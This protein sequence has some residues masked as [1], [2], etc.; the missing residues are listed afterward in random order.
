MN[1]STKD[2]VSAIL[3]TDCNTIDQVKIDEACYRRME[4][5][6]KYYDSEGDKAKRLLRIAAELIDLV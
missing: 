5:V 4:R 3:D 6:C 1:I 2:L